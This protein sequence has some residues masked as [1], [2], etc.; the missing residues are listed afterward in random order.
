MEPQ[1]TWIKI[2]LNSSHAQVGQHMHAQ[3]LFAYMLIS[4]NWWLMKHKIKAICLGWNLEVGTFRNVACSMLNAQCSK[5]HTLIYV[6]LPNCRILGLVFGGWYDNWHVGVGLLRLLLFHSFT[7][8]LLHSYTKENTRVPR[9]DTVH[10][11]RPKKTWR[12]TIFLSP[13][14]L[15]PNL[16]S[17]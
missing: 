8:S 14:I 15:F 11:Y 5:L 10:F 6:G 16:T 1:T 7:L 2:E 13:F 9:L 3:S 17:H 4:H 12:L